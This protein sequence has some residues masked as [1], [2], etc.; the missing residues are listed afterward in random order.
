MRILSLSYCFPSSVDPT[1]GVFILQRLA[2]LGRLVDLEVASPVPVF[3]VLSRLR[4]LPAAREEHGGLAVHYPRFLYVPGILKTMDARLYAAGVRGWLEEY[5]RRR[6]VDLLDAHFVWPDG[7]GVHRLARRLGIPYAITLRGKIYPCL[8]SRSMKRQCA[9]ALRGAAAVISVDSRMADIA[10]DLGALRER[11]HV[12][13]N[14]VDRTF[15]SVQ[16][17][18]A[19]RRRLGLPQDGR[20][21]VTVAH[22]KASKGHGEV[23]QALA[24]LPPDVRLVI[25]GGELEGYRPAL[26]ALVERLGLRDRV[27]LAGKQPYERIPLY[28]SAADASVLASWR[29]GCP[30][31]VLESLAC[32][33]PV[34]ATR[35]GAVP[36][37]VRPDGNG[38]IVPVRDPAALADALR[39]VL[40]R[41]WSPEAVRGSPAVRSWDE[42]VGNV[43]AV[44][45]EALG[46]PAGKTGDARAALVCRVNELYHDLQ[47]AQFNSVHQ[48]RHGVERQF[49]Q[50]VVI[51]R[52]R[53]A[54][55][56]LGVDLC[57][58][59]GFVPGVLLDGL[60]PNVRIMCLDLSEDALRRTRAAL[61]ERADRTPTLKADCRALPLPD[62]AVD[63]VSMNAGLHHVPNPEAVLAEVDRILKPG[64]F[65]CLG[66]E[67]NAAFFSSRFVHGMERVI[68]HAFW[69]LSPWRNLRRVRR[70]LGRAP[71]A[72]EAVEHLDGINEALLKEGRLS[73]PLSLAELRE[74]VDVHTGGETDHG[75]GLYPDDLLR[76]CFPGYEVESLLMTDFGGEMLR[77][78]GWARSAFDAL[79]RMG[80]PRKGRL[81]SWMIRKPS[82]P[83]GVSDR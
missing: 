1:W 14:G 77:R 29:E 44:F 56:A 16:D 54:G 82:K 6:P 22:L 24:Q 43:V 78:H 59:T 32:G 30:N 38:A 42:V 4:P 7:V 79:G 45:K 28:F 74:L 83:E 80:F 34:V 75:A 35:V 5:L 67:P 12:I 76:R 37:L 41:S 81:F 70:R 68:W 3:P 60:G 27:V 9:E 21:L 69:Y 19:A 33:T 49:W 62:G 26:S 13:P 57:T 20:L 47:A 66:Y 36:D 31:V 18:A 23:L 71:E 72:D 8:E 58:G 51:P 73:R 10:V 17:R 25:V 61:G 15:F 64:G 39:R 55:S 2:A 48:F 11:V 52:L 63:W 65:F 40:A 46:R 53:G 50:T